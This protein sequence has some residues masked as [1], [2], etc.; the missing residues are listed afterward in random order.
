M[1]E[2]QLAGL[3]IVQLTADK[4]NQIQERMKAAQD[5]QAMYA[6]KRRKLIEFQVGDNVMLKVSPWK[7][8]VRFGK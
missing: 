2:R 8:I 7:G 4:I 5:W 3:E 1:G 6:N